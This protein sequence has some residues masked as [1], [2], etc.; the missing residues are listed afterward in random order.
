MAPVHLITI[1]Y[2]RPSTNFQN[3]PPR[4]GKNTEIPEITIAQSRMLNIFVE[5]VFNTPFAHSRVGSKIQRLYSIFIGVISLTAGK[6]VL[7]PFAR[8]AERTKTLS[9]ISLKFVDSWGCKNYRFVLSRICILCKSLVLQ[10]KKIHKLYN[11]KVVYI[12]QTKQRMLGCLN[13]A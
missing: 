12:L 1:Q 9:I 5:S 8:A 10:K 13:F 6:M 3:I 2:T 7:I 4:T 11:I